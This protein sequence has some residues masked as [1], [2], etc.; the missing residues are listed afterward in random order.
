MYRGAKRFLALGACSLTIGAGGTT[1]VCDFK[2][3]DLGWFQQLVIGWA[4][5][6]NYKP[7]S[8]FL[9]SRMHPIAKVR[10]Y[11]AVAKSD[12]F[13]KR[14]SSTWLLGRQLPWWGYCSSFLL[15]AAQ[16]A[17]FFMKKGQL[18]NI[19]HE[20]QV[21]WRLPAVRKLLLYLLI[22]WLS[23]LAREYSLQ[24]FLLV[25]EVAYSAGRYSWSCL[26]SIP[27]Q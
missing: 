20:V 25:V 6:M 24:K 1:T 17:P 7:R 15:D 10:F 11:L 4:E 2:W 19:W 14:Y 26:A 21:S 22:G 8:A 12:S 13:W 9:T 16:L 18:L 27:P 5:K 23:S 3:V